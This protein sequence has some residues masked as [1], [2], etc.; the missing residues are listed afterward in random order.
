MPPKPKLP[1]EDENKDDSSTESDGT[2]TKNN[3]EKTK[4]TSSMS[5]DAQVPLIPSPASS[6]SSDSKGYSSH[7]S[8]P[9]KDA[10]SPPIDPFALGSTDSNKSSPS[11]SKDEG[12]DIICEEEEKPPYLI[13]AILLYPGLPLKDVQDILKHIVYTGKQ[14][15]MN[16]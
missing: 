5:Q 6:L 9:V 4:N 2:I 13:E 1:Y 8:P 7:K 15:N 10:K 12:S 14:R 16:I 3:N 11:E